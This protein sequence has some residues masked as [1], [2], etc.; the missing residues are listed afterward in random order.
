MAGIAKFEQ[1]ATPSSR[2]G[3]APR[4]GLVAD[5][6]VTTEIAR[7]LADR[8]GREAHIA[9]VAPAVTRSRLEHVAGIPDE[10]RGEAEERIDRSVP[11]LEEAGLHPDPA[12]VGD[13]D[14]VIAVEDL[15][16]EL[17][18]ELDEIV[19]LT[20]AGDDARWAENDA[21]DRARRRVSLPLTLI[22]VDARGE[23]VEIERSGNGADRPAESV[24]EG[25]SENLPRFATRELLAMIV[26]AVGTIILLVLAGDSI[27][28]ASNPGA[29]LDTSDL[30]VVLL[31]GFFA[32]VNVAHILALTAFQSVGY[33]GLWS[34][35]FARLSLYGTPVAVVAA[36]ILGG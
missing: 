29:G 9:F 6:E 35:F 8:F 32:F 7:K 14:P 4:V 19:L 18:G 23:L 5:H 36:L 34:T 11:R 13:Q 10:A 2:N 31:A 16:R 24:V 22:Q 30:I 28:D 21:F 27:S 12:A 15:M 25:E 1:Q 26:A 17:P 33:R 3:S 20:H